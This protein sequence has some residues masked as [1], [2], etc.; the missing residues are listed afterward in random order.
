MSRIWIGFLTIIFL[1]LTNLVCYVYRNKTS[2]Y[3]SRFMA[4]EAQPLMLEL[5]QY[6][7]RHISGYGRSFIRT[8]SHSALSSQTMQSRV[9]LPRKTVKQHIDDT[10]DISHEEN[11]YSSLYSKY[12]KLVSGQRRSIPKLDICHH[13]INRTDSPM[14]SMTERRGE[15]SCI[16]NYKWDYRR[17]SSIWVNNTARIRWEHHVYLNNTSTV[18]DIGGNTG[19]DATNIVAWFHPKLYVILEPVKLYYDHLVKLFSYKPTVKVFPFGAGS[20]NIQLNI[21]ISGKDGDATSVFTLNTNQTVTIQLFNITE[22]FLG[23]GLSCL[24]V[25]DL[26]TI[27]CEGC[28]FEVLEE[29]LKTNIIL[30]IKNIQFASHTNLPRLKNSKERYCRIQMLLSRTHVIS[31]QYKF[32]WES[33][34]RK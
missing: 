10:L 14:L 9:T 19:L 24:K 13:S 1:A 21:S 5:P 20:T 23:L 4:Q 18:L 11:V 3:I 27:N 26:L 28:E 34:R 25:L 16:S 8:Q 12:I 22:I 33:W 15:R 29:L 30:F 32:I 2:D 31:Y 7:E 6:T 17:G